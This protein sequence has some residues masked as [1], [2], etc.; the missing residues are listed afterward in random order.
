MSFL[1]KVI[2]GLGLLWEAGKYIVCL[3][4]AI[5]VCQRND[6]SGVPSGHLASTC[7]G[8]GSGRHLSD[9]SGSKVTSRFFS[10]Q[11]NRDGGSYYL[12]DMTNLVLIRHGE[13]EW[14]VETRRQG[15]QDD[16]LNDRGVTQAEL[17]AEYVKSVFD[18]DKVWSSPLQRC[19]NT[20]AQLAVPIVKSQFLIEIDYGDWEGKLE[21]E[22][23]ADF[24]GRYQN[25]V[26]SADPPGGEMRSNL[27]LRGRRFMD[28]AGL[29]SADDQSDVVVVGHSSALRGL[30]VALL[31]L[32]D[33]AMDNMVIDNCSVSTVHLANGYNRLTSLNQ[34]QHL[35][36]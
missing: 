14:N 27:P 30:L 6:F 15:R 7:C 25:G 11:P 24:P 21:S 12:G 17:V 18:F 29:N 4:L 35:T 13:T 3:V 19:L 23:A 26:L 1:G 34:T 33:Y 9:G 31:D 32:P 20:A 2:Q 8:T 28:E 22:I 16:S 5:T 36:V 10:R